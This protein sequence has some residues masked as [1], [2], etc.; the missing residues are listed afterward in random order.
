MLVLIIFYMFVGPGPV[1]FFL[2][3]YTV[4]FLPLISFFAILWILKEEVKAYNLNLYLKSPETYKWFFWG[5]KYCLFSHALCTIIFGASNIIT[6]DLISNYVIM[7]VY[8]VTIGVIIEEIVYRKIIFGSLAQKY[9][10]WIGAIVSSII[11]AVGHLNPERMLAYFL[12]GLVLCYAYKKSGTL[13]ASILIHS[14]LNLI[15]LLVRTL[16]G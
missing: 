3:K 4:S 8:T 7:P 5:L 2:N 6:D 11:F 10:F 1:I 15:A 14:S 16:R 12:T 9:H 13:T